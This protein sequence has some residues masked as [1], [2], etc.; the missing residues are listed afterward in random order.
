MTALQTLFVEGGPVLTAIFLLSV[1]AWVL[2]CRC[3]LRSAWLRGQHRIR[4]PQQILAPDRVARHLSGLE[5]T[6][7]IVGITASVLPML[8]LLGTVWGMLVTFEVIQHHGSGQPRLM[9]QGIGQALLTTQAGLWAALPVLG[10]QH[11][12]RSRL[13]CLR[14]DLAGRTAS[15]G[16]QSCQAHRG[17]SHV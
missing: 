7:A 10:L 16:I 12:L 14:R 2:I 6:L 13:R 1:M 3:W 11:I 8:G 5:Q 17:S 9:A 15:S 4:D